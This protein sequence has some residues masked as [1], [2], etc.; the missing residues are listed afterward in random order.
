MN[1]SRPLYKSEQHGGFVA[2]MATIII[3][4]IL[5]VATVDLGILG[6]AARFSI[7]GNENKAQSNALAQ[8]CIQQA[9]AQLLIDGSYRGG[10]TTT[11][12]FGYC[13]VFPFVVD[14]PT[15]GSVTLRVQAVVNQAVTN[16][17]VVKNYNAIHIS[18]LPQSAPI[19][20][21]LPASIETGSIIE[22]P[23]LP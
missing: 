17:V 18:P 11:V 1:K 12:P 20:S 2:L 13:Y 6:A 3:G 7:L 22:V 4:A 15:A 8:S 5:L 10:L 16:L 14:V 23:T 19:I 21:P 9:S